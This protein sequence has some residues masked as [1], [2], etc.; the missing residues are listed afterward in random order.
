MKI[1]IICFL[2]LFGTIIQVTDAQDMQLS[3]DID[4][5]QIQM[6]MDSTFQINELGVLLIEYKLT[7]INNSTANLIFN[8]PISF[9]LP[10]EYEN[11]INAYFVESEALEIQN[12]N[13]MNELV[14]I[15]NNKRHTIVTIDFRNEKYKYINKYE[16]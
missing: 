12:I 8:E 2:L 14:I 7:I 3:S 10:K 1:L 6:K 5:S 15:S 4:K 13:Y 11:K 16:L 9:F